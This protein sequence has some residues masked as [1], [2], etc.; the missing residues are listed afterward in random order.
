MRIVETLAAVVVAEPVVVV[1]AA[2][3]GIG[4]LTH[5]CSRIVVRHSRIARA[6]L[7]PVTH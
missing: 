4:R 7:L 1:A 5:L 3:A 2:N 6:A